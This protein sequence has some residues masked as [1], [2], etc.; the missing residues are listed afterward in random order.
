MQPSFQTPASAGSSRDEAEYVAAELTTSP[1]KSRTR[2]QTL[3]P[4]HLVRDIDGELQLGPLLVLGEDVAFFR[5]SEAAL[6]R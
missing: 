1:R 6:R 4:P 5:R 2:E 3:P